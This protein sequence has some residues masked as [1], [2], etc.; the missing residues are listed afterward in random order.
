[1]VIGVFFVSIQLVSTG[2][3]G[4]YVGAVLTQMQHQPYAIERR[5]VDREYEPGETGFAGR[6]RPPRRGVAQPPL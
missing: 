5:R 2:I 6:G 3:L 4:E 1:M